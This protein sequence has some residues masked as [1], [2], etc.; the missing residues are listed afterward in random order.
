L[1][2]RDRPG[3][4]DTEELFYPG[5]CR[6][7]PRHPTRPCATRFRVTAGAVAFRDA[8]QGEYV[9]DVASSIG[10]FIVRRRDGLFAYQL[11]VVV[12]DA[13]QDVTEVVR[14]CD[15]LS[16]TPRQMLLQRALGLATPEYA[17]LPL[18][19]EPAGEKLA[20][21]RRSVPVEAESASLA[22][23]SVLKLLRQS[24]P[25]ELATGPVRTLWSWALAHWN[26]HALQ[27]ISRI[28]L[29]PI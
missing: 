26:P 1:G 16:N 3:A 28:E 27:G 4:A 21:S 22:V 9:Q 15:L 8:L 20:K 19:V 10:D 14:G 6:E 2:A 13:A 12:D 7:G 29:E 11:A 18:L 17:H 5:F 23:Y 24:P 25:L